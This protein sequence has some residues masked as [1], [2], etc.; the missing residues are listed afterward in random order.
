MSPKPRVGVQIWPGGTPDYP[1]WRQAVIDVESLGADVIF[2]YDHFHK[3]FVEIRDG[4]PHLL[5]EQH[6]VNNFEGWTALASWGEITSRAEIGLLVTGIGYRNPELLADM[7]RTVDHTSSG[8]LILGVGSGWYEKDYAAYGYDFPPLGERMR[9]FAEGLA[10][11]EH[12]LANLTPPPVRDIPILIG[13]SGERK[14]LPLVGRYADIWHSFEPLDEFKRK[15]DIVK[16]LADQAG[17]DA[18]RIERG[19]AWEGPAAADAYHAA[20]VSLFTTEVKPTE[21]GYDL[22]VVKE[23]IAWRDGSR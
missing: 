22:T 2:G 4:G 9:L 14:T 3:P 7:A 19:T 17:R 12:R 20:G 16:R 15:D 18:S 6:D 1:T 10:R 8:R 21:T 13:G 5:P 23:M 11:I